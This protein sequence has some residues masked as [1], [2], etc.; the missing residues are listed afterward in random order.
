MREAHLAVK[1][2]YMSFY[3]NQVQLTGRLAA[4]PELYFASDGVPK[5]NLVLVQDRNRGVEED[6]ETFLLVGWAGLA[7]R[8]QET[9]RQGDRLFVQGRL[10]TRSF[11][12]DGIRHYRT[13]VHLEQFVPLKS[14]R[15]VNRLRQ[16]RNPGEISTTESTTE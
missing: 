6:P 5:A 7:R 1:Q 14:S 9:M 10:R 11:L 13:E 12:R 16:R 3:H 15:S 8:L 4:D 2:Q